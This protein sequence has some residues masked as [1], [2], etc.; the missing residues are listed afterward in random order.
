MDDASRASTLNFLAALYAIILILALSL[1]IL[2]MACCA[3]LDMVAEIRRAT[4]PRATPTHA[5]VEIPELTGVD[6]SH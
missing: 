2:L 5:E 3:C 1:Y 4:R 6:S